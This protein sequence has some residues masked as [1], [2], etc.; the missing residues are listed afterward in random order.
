VNC[1]YRRCRCLIASAC[2]MAMSQPVSTHLGSIGSGSSA[3]SCTSKPRLTCRPT[4]LD[5]RRARHTLRA[6]DG[7]SNSTRQNRHSAVLNLFTRK[8]RSGTRRRWLRLRHVGW[9]PAKKTGRC[10]EML[11]GRP[12]RRIIVQL[13]LSSPTVTAVDTLLC[14]EHPSGGNGT[15]SWYGQ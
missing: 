12:P 9:S 1:R 15:N 2:T 4:L 14:F 11:A 5:H 8:R 6:Q 3:I 7:P 13:F 10:C